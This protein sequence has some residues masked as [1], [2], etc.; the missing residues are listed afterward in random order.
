MRIFVTALIVALALT[1]SAFAG[2]VA[3]SSLGAT[4]VC[5]G[6][7]TPCSLTS[8]ARPA[9]NTIDGISGVG[10]NADKWVAP[11][12][13]QNPGVLVN[14]GQLYTIDSITISGVG[15]VG[16]SIDFEVFVGTNP[17][18]STTDTAVG[19][20]ISGGSPVLVTQTVAGQLWSDTFTV[21]TS[22]PIQYI[23]YDVTSALGFNGGTSPDDAYANDIAADSPVP[24]P[25]TL[26]MIGGAGLLGLG[27]VKRRFQR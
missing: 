10:Q 4:A 9:S 3:L 21:S 15:N 12:S 26:S 20:L 8:P 22:S 6:T 1:G 25:G 27:F 17:L 23:L 7:P 14:L 13:T 5:D 24:E 2:N 16:N 11:G 18:L 19:T